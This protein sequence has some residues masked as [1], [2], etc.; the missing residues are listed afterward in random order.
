LTCDAAAGGDR[1][2]RFCHHRTVSDGAYAPVPGID[3]KDVAFGID[4]DTR[5]LRQGPSSGQKSRPAITRKT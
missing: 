2:T 4:S 5:R 1:G 3:K